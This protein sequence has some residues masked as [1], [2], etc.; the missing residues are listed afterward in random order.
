L[1]GSEHPQITS[2]ENNKTT[3]LIYDKQALKE[4][5]RAEKLAVS[6]MQERNQVDK[7]ISEQ[8]NDL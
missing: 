4:K 5:S 1:I 2:R 6:I 3:N 7:R 8:V